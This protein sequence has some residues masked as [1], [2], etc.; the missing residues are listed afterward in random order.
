MD[1]L[2]EQNNQQLRLRLQLISRATHQAMSALEGR[3]VRLNTIM[4]ICVTLDV[5]FHQVG[6]ISARSEQFVFLP[7][8]YSQAPSAND[9]V[10]SLT[11][12]QYVDLLASKVPD[13]LIA[14]HQVGRFLQ[15]LH[16]TQHRRDSILIKDA[17][18]SSLSRTESGNTRLFVYGLPERKQ[19]QT[20]G[21]YTK[22]YHQHYRSIPEPLTDRGRAKPAWR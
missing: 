9:S 7:P 8:Y 14:R 22:T 13:A 2:Q 16:Q 11:Q 17:P 6:F 4:N 19:E 1:Q 20:L 3:C 21:E 10:M 18:A 15:Q 5:A 12:D